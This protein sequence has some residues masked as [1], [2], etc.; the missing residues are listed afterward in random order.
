[1]DW[2]AFDQL[3]CGLYLISSAWEGAESGCIVNTVQ[4]VTA[5]PPQLAVTINKNSYTGELIGKSGLFEAT[6]LGQQVGLEEIGRFGF[7]SGREVQKFEGIPALRDE[8]G[9]PYV[10]KG[11]A[12]RFSCRI[13]GKMDVGTHWIF[14]GQ[15]EQAERLEGEPMTY[16]YY[17]QVK[18]GGT[19]KEAPSYQGEE[20]EK[21][22]QKG[23]R[24]KLCG[25][26]W[27][28][29]SLPRDFICPICKK[30]PDYMVP[31]D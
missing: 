16:A 4:Q 24:C 14:V 29:E 30:G 2:K 26:V 23:W 5:E 19:P 21:P 28:G 27:E 15:V 25:Y 31:L 7:Q 1:M 8:A 3:S 6:V 12:A 11:M 9:I 22:A 10:E 20:A 18:K 13:T 17:H